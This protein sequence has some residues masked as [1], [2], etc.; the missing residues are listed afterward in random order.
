MQL[1]RLRLQASLE[2]CWILWCR[3]QVSAGQ[4]SDKSAPVVCQEVWSFDD[5]NGVVKLEGLQALCP[6]VHLAKHVL[7]QL[8]DKQR[9]TALWTLQAMNECVSSPTKG[10]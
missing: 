10:M 2:L 7:V 1:F 5:E 4:G 6:E 9:Q 3:C 8:D